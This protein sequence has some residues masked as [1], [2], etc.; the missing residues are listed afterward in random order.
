MNVKSGSTSEPGLD[1]A[2]TERD[3][4]EEEEDDDDDEEKGGKGESLD[5]LL[6]RVFGSVSSMARQKRMFWSKTA[7]CDVPCG[8][9]RDDEEE[10][11][12]EEED[13]DRD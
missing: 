8:E 7:D 2:A 9:E 10:E 1:E 4:E 12:E 13:G 6:R 11:E 5:A 3:E